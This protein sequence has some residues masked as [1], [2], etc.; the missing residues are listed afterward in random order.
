MSWTPGSDLD[1]VDGARSIVLAGRRGGLTV[2]QA[3]ETAVR[4]RS[5]S[6]ST[7]AGGVVADAMR[8]RWQLRADQ[9]AGFEPQPGDRLAAGD[10]Y[11]TV[12]SAELL[13]GQTRWALE[14][15][16]LPEGTSWT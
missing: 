3:V 16:R 1:L 14:C 4:Q 7:E 9:L 10:E 12:Q 8:C 11:W 15:T 6:Q 13:G 2:T 5:Q